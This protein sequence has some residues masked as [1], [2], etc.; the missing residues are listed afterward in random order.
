M[1]SVS[2]FIIRIIFAG[3]GLLQGWI[4]DHVSLNIALIT[5]GI[6]YLLVAVISATSLLKKQS[7][8]FYR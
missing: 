1:L 3:I 4:T 2:N 8:I 6:T 5:A 7:S